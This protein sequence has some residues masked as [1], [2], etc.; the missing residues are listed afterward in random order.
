MWG[1]GG[2]GKKRVKV[3]RLFPEAPE[4]RGTRE[5]SESTAGAVTRR[6]SGRHRGRKCGTKYTKAATI[7]RTNL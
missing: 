6:L 5:S 7:T 4:E 2:K 1:D 3:E